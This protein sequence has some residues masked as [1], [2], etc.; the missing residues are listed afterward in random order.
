M[1]PINKHYLNKKIYKKCIRRP[2]ISNTTFRCPNT[3]CNKPFHNLS[4]VTMHLRKTNDC[5]NAILQNNKNKKYSDINSFIESHFEN[6][7]D[8]ISYNNSDNNTIGEDDISD[9]NNNTNSFTVN[10][11]EENKKVL[12]MIFILKL[13]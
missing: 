4:Q 10:S 11:M 1:S 5:A 3:I 2:N 9:M 12:P 6:D 8:N 13:N 7:N